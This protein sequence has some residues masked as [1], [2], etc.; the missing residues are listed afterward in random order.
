MSSINAKQPLTRLREQ[1]QKRDVKIQAI[2]NKTKT[3][4]RKQDIQQKILV[5]AYYL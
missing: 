1:R 3:A 2:E 5:G 4:E